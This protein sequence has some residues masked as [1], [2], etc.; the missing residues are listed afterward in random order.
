MKHVKLFEAFLNERVADYEYLVD[1][2]LRA[3]PEYS[4]YYNDSWR[5]VNVGGTG[6]DKADL[7]KQ[8]KASPGHSQKIKDNFYL[9]AQNPAETMKQI[10]KLSKGQIEVEQDGKLLKYT[11]K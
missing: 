6:Y 8:F 4:V 9:A 2:L 7:V 3:N 5:V 10:D 1:L 11:V